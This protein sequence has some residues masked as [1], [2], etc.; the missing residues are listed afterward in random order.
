MPTPPDVPDRQVFVDPS[1][2][3]RRLVRRL[4]IATCALLAA[5]TVLL[6][7]ALSG[8]PIPPSALLPL[9]S[10]PAT[11]ESTATTDQ[12]NPLPAETTAPT[13]HSTHA[14]TETT[15]ASVI[16]P[17]LTPQPTTGT[18]VTTTSTTGNRHSHAPTAPPG[19]TKHTDSTPA[20]P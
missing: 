4:A 15:T 13:A 14:T 10:A 1:G 18:T 11:V 17:T 19:Q 8:A 12:Q 20:T 16:R 9:P 2:R 5:Y 3:R 7:A 6:C